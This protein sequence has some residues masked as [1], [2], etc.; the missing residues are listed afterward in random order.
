MGIAESTFPHPKEWRLGTATETMDKLT[1][2]ALTAA[3]SAIKRV[4]PSCIGAWQQRIG[5]LPHDIGARYNN[6]LLTPK[7][8]H[9][10]WRLN[11]RL[12]SFHALVSRDA[13]AS[14]F[15]LQ[16]CLGPLC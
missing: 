7:D 6:S 12:A 9:S 15:A 8:W 3:I 2:R 1:V 13:T 11:C 4:E 16:T 14:D 5:Q 10:Y